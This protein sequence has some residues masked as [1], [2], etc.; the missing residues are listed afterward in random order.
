MVRREETSAERLRAALRGCAS[1]EAPPDNDLATLLSLAVSVCDVPLAAITFVDDEHESLCVTIGCDRGRFPR[2]SSFGAHVMA[3]GAPLVV[4]DAADDTRFQHHGL[5]SGAPHVRFYAGVP[6]A[7]Q[8]GTALG[9][10]SVI[11]TEARTASSVPLEQLQTIAR[12]VIRELEVRHAQ[13]GIGDAPLQ[14]QP[15]S[16]EPFRWLVERSL[17][18]LY[19][20]K[21]GRIVY[22]N[23]AFC[24]IVG[25][26]L[27][28]L[29]AFSS[30][31]EFTLEEDRAAVAEQIRRRL[32]S[33]QLESRYTARAVRKDGEIRHVDILG[34]SVQ[35]GDEKLLIGTLIDVT[36]RV[37]A[38]RSAHE[39]QALFE[40]FM[41]NSP[42]VA[43]IQDAAG[44]YVWANRTAREVTGQDLAGMRGRTTEDFFNLATA[45]ELRQNDELVLRTREARTF[46][47][48]MRGTDAPM[49]PRWL[50]VKFPIES[51]SGELLL[52]G[53]SIDVTEREHL[54]EQLEST[55]RQ[56]SSIIEH[57]PTGV[58]MI[59]ADGRFSYVSAR[60]REITG[61]LDDELEAIPS[62]EDLVH[63]DD[64][65]R[66]YSLFRAKLDAGAQRTHYTARTLR[67]DGAVRNVEVFSSSALTIA[68]KQAVI[69]T[70]LDVTD[71]VESEERLRMSEER[72]RSIVQNAQEIIFE[73]NV[74]G[75][76]TSLNTAFEKLTGWRT[77]DWVGRSF[78]GL[79]RPEDRARAAEAFQHNLTSDSRSSGVYGFVAAD[80]R[81]V[82]LET[83]SQVHLSGGKPVCVR[84]IARDVTERV[85]AEAAQR[86][87]TRDMELLLASTAEGIYGLDADGRC[88]FVNPAAARLL[89]Y[90]AEEML[91][92]NIHHLVHY[93]KQD[94]TPYPE[95]D[96]PVAHVLAHGGSLRRHGEV[97]WRKDGSPLLVDYSTSA[98]ADGAVRKGAVVAMTDITEQV[99]LQQRLE[100]ANRVDS[101]GRVAATIAHEFNNVLMSIQPFAEALIRSIPHDVYLQG[102]SKQI[103]GAVD[104][105]KRVTEDILRFTRSTH[106][107]GVRIDVGRWLR[108]LRP[109]LE[110]YLRQGMTLEL[111]IGDDL[112]VAGDPQQLAQVM[113]NLVANARD[114]MPMDGGHL[115]IAARAI[116]R[117]AAPG[118]AT[119]EMVHISVQDNGTGIAPEILPRIFEPL[120]TTKSIG[121]TGLG[122]AV[123]KQLIERHGGEIS[124]R[125]G[126]RLG[127]TFDIYLPA[128]AA[129][130]MSAAPATPRAALRVTKVVLV[131]DEVSVAAGLAALLELED[132]QVLPVMTGGEAV[133][134]I[135]RYDPQAVI[136]DL[137]LP[138]I[139]GVAVFEQIAARW[140]K[141]PVVFSTGHG[142]ESK[143]REFL[144]LPHVSFL[145]KPYG[146][147]TLLR[148]LEQ[149]TRA[150]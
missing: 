84:G 64:R 81:E 41:D 103:L 58:F 24:D 123:A 107:V 93:K 100:Q 50:S 122:L 48:G 16:D 149:V 114:A 37:D 14:P 147:E 27:D 6:L 15:V 99:E 62:V 95:E 143:L 101:L 128:G 80:G 106:M 25:Y 145:M 110:G 78:D 98:L 96:C 141:L 140:P 133:A 10:L 23:R 21:G 74:D 121:G 39:T 34:T 132:I 137:G 85:R 104:R 55:E 38:E 119:S 54:R 146:V 130:S 22:A 109:Q 29:K 144:Q 82:L 3:G 139:D 111:I 18:G 44:R 47:E 26:S 40:T 42:G 67:K 43:F 17:A 127:T 46:L 126:A 135:E 20:A 72:Y 88:V 102:L 117:S 28:E 49:P 150:E 32:E 77:S 131:E 91:G 73:V 19:I 52:G 83:S 124:V 30:V 12:A 105:G 35:V 71:R 59:G 56:L 118:A 66:V 79:L 1:A 31:L 92:R 2:E 148:K 129:A 68:G 125:T 142:D 94:G 13:T 9:T 70:L 53:I 5:V 69:G 76:I 36:A 7:T 112:V 89:G 115:S 108:E 116:T 33:G 86:E 61:Y 138:D 120:F 60:W 8:D 134:A 11:D 63:A 87:L 113:T 97:F 4:E 75:T 45:T 136:L 65:E 90:D 57:N 51:P